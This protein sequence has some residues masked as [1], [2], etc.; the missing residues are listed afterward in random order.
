MIHN[1]RF[2]ISKDGGGQDIRRPAAL[3][4]SITHRKS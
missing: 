2:A 1:L 4:S 3:K